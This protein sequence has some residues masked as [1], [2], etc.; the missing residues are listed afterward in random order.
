MIYANNIKKNGSK[1]ILEQRNIVSSVSS[2][3]INKY[4]TEIPKNRGPKRKATPLPH[5][6]NYLRKSSTQPKR[7]FA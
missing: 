4:T 7:N 1:H 5:N 6:H 3:N 2:S